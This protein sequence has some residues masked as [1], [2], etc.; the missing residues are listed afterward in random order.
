[1]LGAG[2]ARG[3]SGSGDYIAG[4]IAERLSGDSDG[5]RRPNGSAA[6]I[7]ICRK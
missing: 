6:Q 5:K 2:V 1:M 7:S 4:G 3:T